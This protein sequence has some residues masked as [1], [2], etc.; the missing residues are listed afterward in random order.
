[1]GGWKSK[2]RAVRGRWI[3]RWRKRGYPPPPVWIIA[4]VLVLAGLASRDSW[5]AAAALSSNAVLLIWVWMQGVRREDR[6]ISRERTWQAKD[7][8]QKRRAP[9][10]GEAMLTCLQRCREAR[11]FF[12]GAGLPEASTASRH[13]DAIESELLKSLAADIEACNTYWASNVWMHHMARNAERIE[14]GEL[15]DLCEPKDDDQPQAEQ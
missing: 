9:G 3:I 6:R 14:I 12:E 13:L 1:M 11:S 10:P 8:R 2:T 5:A 7:D 15:A 4:A